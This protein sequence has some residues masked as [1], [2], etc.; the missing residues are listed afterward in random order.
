M[1]SE[2]FRGKKL[3]TLLSLDPCEVMDKCKYVLGLLGADLFPPFM[4]L[5]LLLLRCNWDQRGRGVI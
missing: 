4:E 1:I 2:Q 5:L 3:K